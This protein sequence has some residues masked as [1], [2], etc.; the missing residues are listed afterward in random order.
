[1]PTLLL[2]LSTL[3]NVSISSYL[4]VSLC[5]IPTHSHSA[6]HNS[7]SHNYPRKAILLWW[8]HAVALS[9][10]RLVVTPPHCPSPTSIWAC[11]WSLLGRR[12]KAWWWLTLGCIPRYIV[13]F[14]QSSFNLTVFFPYTKGKRRN[15]LRNRTDTWSYDIDQLL[16]GTVLFTLI[17]FLFPTALVYYA[18][19]AGVGFSF[20]F[21]SI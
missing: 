15:V 4:F 17:A 3:G 5:L 1:M 13:L 16:F 8:T 19:F 11:M 9:P 12:R 10:L 7:Y 18:L 21:P 2:V 14:Y 6:T 20:H